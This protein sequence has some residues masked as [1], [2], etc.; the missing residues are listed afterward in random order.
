MTN[1]E[2]SISDAT[3][4]ALVAALKIGLPC[5]SDEVSTA[6]TTLRAQLAEVSHMLALSKLTIEAVLA[7]ADR[8][9]QRVATL[10]HEVRLREAALAAQIEVGKTE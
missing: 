4:D 5:A 1:E 10:E 7:R 2:L 3:L 9:E 6:I 8:A